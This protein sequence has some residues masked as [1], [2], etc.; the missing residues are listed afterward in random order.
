MREVRSQ[1]IVWIVLCLLF[2]IPAVFSQYK[3][4]SSSKEPLLVASSTILGNRIQVYLVYGIEDVSISYTSSSSSHQWYRYKTKAAEREKIQSSQQGT[5]SVLN[6]LVEGY[7]YAVI[8]GDDYVSAEYIWLIDYSKYPVDIQNL[9]VN[10][11]TDPCMSFQL[12]GTDLTP[13]L[14]YHTPAGVETQVPRKYEISY[15]SLQ[16][17]ESS[18]LF[19]KIRIIDT[20]D[21]PIRKSIKDIPLCDTG[22]K[23]E[24]DLFAYHFGVGKTYTIDHFEAS[25]VEVY[26]DTLILSEG[27][28]NL[29]YDNTKELLAPAEVR[30]TAYANKPVASL[31]RWRIVDT[32]TNIERINFVGEELEYTFNQA[33]DYKISLEVSDRSGK[34]T[35]DEITYAIS[36]TETQMSVPNAFTPVGSPGINDVFK[37]AH[38]SVVSF[39]GWIFNRWGSELFHWNDPSQGWNGK[40]RG[41]Y[42]PAGPYFYVIEYTGT[43]GKKRKKSGDVNV[44]HVKD[45]IN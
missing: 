14:F 43:D 44:I 2:H 20:L 36:I 34:C 18:K 32:R 37:V 9:Q 16:W 6:S 19:T 23:L 22:V 42:V 15:E 27:V 35:N 3:V 7:A 13:K 11:E 33:G 24:G 1:K 12:N 26:A 41:K 45:N 4:E 28:T 21:N 40:Y 31:F 29:S 39:K 38:K 8:E 5:T 17:Q 30:F 10:R 25:K